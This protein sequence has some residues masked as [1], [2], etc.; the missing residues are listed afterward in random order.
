[1]SSFTN[2]L[3]VEVLDGY[4]FRLVDPF[5]Y[6][7]GRYP[8]DDVIR[9]PVGFVTDFASIPRLFWSI[10]PPHGSYAKA[11]MVHDYLYTYGTN[12]RKYADDVFN[13][14]MVVLGVS[15]LTR[16]SMYWAVRI[17]GASRYEGR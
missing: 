12:G 17:F 14:G 15:K 1:M 10:I 2:A 3:N 11:A 6:H 8:S 9:V 4:R 16:A 13:E 5:E 7:V